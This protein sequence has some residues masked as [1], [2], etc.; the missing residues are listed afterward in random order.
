[1]VGLGLTGLTVGS[2]LTAPIA[3]AQGA[4]QTGP[5]DPTPTSEAPCPNNQGNGNAPCNGTVGNADD[6]NPP[7]QQ[8]GGSDNNKGYECDGNNGVGNDGGNPAHTGCTTP[9]SSD[10]G[11]DNGG[12]G[13]NGGGVDN[14]T[15][16]TGEVLGETLVAPLPGS[17]ASGDVAG[18]TVTAPAVQAT[19]ATSPGQLAFTGP[20]TLT[21]ALAIVGAL[22]LLFGLALVTA[23]KEPTFA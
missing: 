2:T 8:P 17:P 14:S 9:S 7:G 15:S 18:E 1:V 21:I 23:T 12:N 20:G 4:N 22:M 5:Y 13:G 10:T 6:K 3:L 11:G 16:P 19:A